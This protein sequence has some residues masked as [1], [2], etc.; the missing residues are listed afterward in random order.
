MGKTTK[1]VNN[2]PHQSNELLNSES[3]SF[4]M[5]DMS[6]YIKLINVVKSIDA[7]KFLTANTTLENRVQEL[8]NVNSM[9]SE[10]YSN[11][12]IHS[13]FENNELYNLFENS[14]ET[15]TEI[16]NKKL[17][18]VDENLEQEF[19]IINDDLLKFQQEAINK[20][21]EQENSFLPKTKILTNNKKV[22]KDEL[23]R[24][25]REI[26]RTRI[27]ANQNYILLAND[28]SSKNEQE[29]LKFNHS[30]E[31]SIEKNIYDKSII[32]EDSLEKIQRLDLETNNIEAKYRQ[33]INDKEQQIIQNTIKLNNIITQLGVEYNNR[34]KYAYIPYEIKSNKLIDEIGENEKSYNL[35]EE[36]VL[37]E[38]KSL[39]QEN[40]N[41]IGELREE[42]KVVLDTYLMNLKALKIE[43]NSSLQKEINIIDKKIA[44]AS[45]NQNS[46]NK[47]ET[48]ALIKKLVADKK[49]FIKK[50]N[51]LKLSKIQ[52]LK[53]KHLEYELDYIEK[54]E[55]LRSKKSECEAIKSS[56]MKNVNY[57][58][59]YHHERINSEL[60]L[61]YSE[62]DSF[63]T[64]DH[65]EENKE[66]Y[67]KRLNFEI[68]NEGIRYEINEID[69]NIFEEKVTTRYKKDKITAEKEY[70][71]SLCDADLEYQMSS[72]KSR[73]DYFNVKAMLDIKKENIINEFEK[74]FATEKTEFEKI[75]YTYYN[76]CDNL[77]YDIYKN[78][79]DLICK[80]IDE[81]VKHHQDLAE[82][83]KTH[84][85][86]INNQQKNSLVNEHTH[87][88]NLLYI[89]L[90]KNRLEVEKTMLMDLYETYHL[91]ITN[92]FE[93]EKNFHELICN[94]SEAS[95][96]SNK[97]EIL[98]SLE[99]IRQI[100][101]DILK[102]YHQKEIQIINNR[103]NFEKSIKFNKQI[104]STR[105]ELETLMADL[106]S[107]IEKTSQK[108][109]SHK[110]TLLLSFEAINILR[111][112]V[113]D[114]QKELISHKHTKARKLEIKKEIAEYK[115]N[116]LLLKKQNSA[117]I[118]NVRK[119][120][121]LKKRQ[122]EELKK[123]EKM[124]QARFDKIRRAQ[125][126]DEKIYNY[127]I[128]LIERQYNKIKM[129]ISSC[130]QIISIYKYTYE[131]T[132]VARVKINEINNIVFD[133][134]ENY[135]DIQLNK[136]D[137]LFKKQYNL[138]KDIHVKNYERYLK[139]LKITINIEAKEYNTNITT[140]TNAYH[141]I[142]DTL[143]RQAAYDEGKLLSELK[144]VNLEQLENLKK[145]EL[146]M[147]EISEQ[148]QY[149]LLCHEENCQMHLNQYNE[150]N[151]NIINTYMAKIKEIK[152]TY[153]QTISDLN[154]KYSQAL[155]R[156]KA[157]HASNILLK[158]NN[159]INIT[160]EYKESTKKTNLKIK[161]IIQDDKIAKVR[162]EENKKIRHK[163][164]LL[165]QKNTRK[166]F[167]IQTE[168]II[169]KCNARIKALQK[170]FK[171]E[172][173]QKKD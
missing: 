33:M 89:N 87:Q 55:Q 31:S 143:K 97:K 166:E 132:G 59:V 78:T 32:N 108:I 121:I 67:S 52:F 2:F 61:V 137:E 91:L 9:I 172:F 37:N 122:I 1:Q 81:D 13:I 60:K 50:H 74:K 105:K 118:A 92:I 6:L 24:I 159:N 40:D 129:N 158:K 25:I 93:F 107:K 88:E 41:E 169:K 96:N 167:S 47:K 155:K 139:E 102:K 98:I 43:F 57:E 104:D 156:V 95:F 173:L 115:E 27:A 54:Y 171:K 82:I 165:N 135:F 123:K 145:Y 23:Y 109:T 56:A 163:L 58:R 5:G 111:K 148:K 168:Q 79:N 138:Q 21:K 160:N 39:L 83:E 69:L 128:D 170:A 35:I 117:N 75:K 106:N 7:F 120:N 127:L 142:V 90:Y 51:L 20:Y 70:N 3:S 42:H 131:Y 29:Q 157:Q 12:Y 53:H 14:V 136:F 46:T 152:D 100:K 119:L 8:L 44:I 162:H 18:E 76:T 147:K 149:E 38:F 146:K 151:Q 124:Y 30:I 103:L 64:Q 4:V 73:I 133:Q 45:S 140:A 15:N 62:K 11:K 16:L 161:K 153:R 110:N 22:N 84:K 66:I 80:I 71:I 86:A 114:T 48:V 77:Q 34:L 28:I 99:L 141:A 113:L 144:K 72:I 94:L 154:L 150:K 10:E 112:K 17:K 19:I 63:T 49:N 85:K 164:Y 125:A 68:E 134:S 116:I 36:Q 65:Y 126:N 26:N 130:G 101:L